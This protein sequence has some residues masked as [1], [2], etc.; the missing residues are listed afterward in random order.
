MLRERAPS[1][2]AAQVL[3]GQ[4]LG[5]APAQGL[6]LEVEYDE[7]GVGAASQLGAAAVARA[8]EGLTEVAVSSSPYDGGC[9]TILFSRCSTGR[10]WS[11]QKAPGYPLVMACAR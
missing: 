5:P 1:A 2:P 6:E 8:A 9:N 3:R 10:P 7:V 11:S 4:A